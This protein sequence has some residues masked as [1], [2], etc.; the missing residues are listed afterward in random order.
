MRKATDAE[1]R[2][3]GVPPA[4]T[5]V[6]VST[7]PN[8]DLVATAR[9]PNGK[10]FYRY[11]AAFVER[12]A[13]AKWDR[14]KRLGAKA[15]KIEKR[16]LRDAQSGEDRHVAMCAWLIMLTGMR[17]GNPPQGKD[18]SYG[19]SSLLLEHTNV[20]KDE[21]TFDFV[22]KKGVQQHYVVR[23]ALLAGY[24]RE[25]SHE[26]RL[27]PHDANATLRYLKSIGAAKVHDLRTWRANE[28]ASILI[29]E[30]LK[31]G[32]PESKKAIKA[33]KKLVATKVAEAL[34]NSPSM[35]LKSYIDPRAWRVFE[36]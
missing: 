27:F 33:F 5:D 20:R 30:L 32:V 18:Q 23:D 29:E 12:Q 16:I 7:D 3:L 31:H 11:S 24:V 19:A 13:A 8:A 26:A 14:V 6:M 36:D 25:R 10:T 9:I 35:A 4:Y 15:E 22:G 34:G 1:K 17:N 2:A 21:V 28:L